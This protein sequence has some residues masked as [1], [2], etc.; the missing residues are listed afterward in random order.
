MDEGPL[1]YEEGGAKKRG[2]LLT[3]T[4][5]TISASAGVP[6]LRL[7]TDSRGSFS[8]LRSR[9]SSSSSE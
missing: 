2:F 1:S 9:S 4:G 5:H 6:E 3:A 8:F 7:K